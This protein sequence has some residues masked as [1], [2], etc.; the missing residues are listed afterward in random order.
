M[1]SSRDLTASCTSIGETSQPERLVLAN[2]LCRSQGVLG[3]LPSMHSSVRE[4]DLYVTKTLLIN[5]QYSVLLV[6]LQP[7]I[8]DSPIIRDPSMDLA[9]VPCVHRHTGSPGLPPWRSNLLQRHP[10]SWEQ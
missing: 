10:I 9:Q 8:R 6:L 4:T 5:L 7:F 3:L 1:S 2:L